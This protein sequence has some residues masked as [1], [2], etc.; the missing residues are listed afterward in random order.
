MENI[1]KYAIAFAFIALP[2]CAMEM[3]S[4]EKTGVPAAGVKPTYGW[5]SRPRIASGSVST[6]PSS[7]TQE[8]SAH[9][10]RRSASRDNLPR[11]NLRS[12][13]PINGIPPLHTS[14]KDKKPSPEVS[15]SNE[16]ASATTTQTPTSKAYVNYK[17]TEDATRKA[18]LDKVQEAFRP[19]SPSS[20]IKAM[21]A[22]ASLISVEANPKK[23][24]LQNLITL[25]G[26]IT[27]LM[28]KV[29]TLQMSSNSNSPKSDSSDDENRA[30]PV[31]DL[32][33]SSHKKTAS[34]GSSQGSTA[35]TPGV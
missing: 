4:K 14:S 35:S 11:G 17:Q 25:Q 5:E 30:V 22:E 29:A 34:N 9:T 15:P 26:H 33:S 6:G 20:K 24:D 8:I 18:K 12:P 19:L 28:Q 16:N 1:K 23:D 3:E 2:C 32:S 10:A 7:A 13:S 31:L 27:A 21:L